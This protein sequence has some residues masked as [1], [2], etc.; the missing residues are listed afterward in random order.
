[1]PSLSAWKLHL[2]SVGQTIAVSC[3]ALLLGFGEASL[4]QAQTAEPS[5]DDLPLEQIIFEQLL[6]L[7]ST[8]SPGV[9]FLSEAAEDWPVV[10]EETTSLYR[11]TLPSFWWSRDQMP[12][13]WRASDDSTVRVAGYRLIRNWLAFHSTTLDASVVD[14][15]VDPQY[16]NRL[17]YYQQYAILRQLGTTGLN[18]GYHVRIYSSIELEGVYACDFTS[19]HDRIDSP[20]AELS[21]AQMGQ[22]DC[23]AAIGPFVDFTSPEFGE[24]LFAPP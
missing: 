8:Y 10:T 24:D 22:V 13:V 7:P 4:V 16:W 21:L 2:P 9:G 20:G 15:Q 3:G 19:V 14:V 23:T 12:T 17:N 1:M 6:D 11:P 5:P 18:Y